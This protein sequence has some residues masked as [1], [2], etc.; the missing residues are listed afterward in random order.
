MQLEGIDHVAMGVRDI[1]R[2]AKWLRSVLSLAAAHLGLVRPRSL[3]ARCFAVALLFCAARGLLVSGD[4]P[5]HLVP[6]QHETG[7]SAVSPADS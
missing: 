5:D 4:Q 6:L 2:S 3:R 7:E 1:E